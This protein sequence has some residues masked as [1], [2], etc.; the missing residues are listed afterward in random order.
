[1]HTYEKILQAIGQ[2]AIG[3]VGSDGIFDTNKAVAISKQLYLD[4]TGIAPPDI[5]ELAATDIQQLKA[6]IAALVKQGESLRKDFPVQIAFD[7]ILNDLRQL[8]AV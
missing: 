6:E 5:K 4:I 7:N 3:C 1:L 8:L 2:A